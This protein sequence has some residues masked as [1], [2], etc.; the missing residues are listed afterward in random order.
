[1]LVVLDSDG[2]L[3]MLRHTVCGFEGPLPQVRRLKRFRSYFQAGVME[4]SRS[5]TESVAGDCMNAWKPE[6]PT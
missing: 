5:G 1:M 6:G 4:D 3:R 2:P